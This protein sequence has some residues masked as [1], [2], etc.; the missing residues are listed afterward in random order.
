MSNK[1]NRNDLNKSKIVEITS[2][3]KLELNSTK[4]TCDKIILCLKNIWLGKAVHVFQFARFFMFWIICFSLIYA[5]VN[6]GKEVNHSFYINTN[7]YS[8]AFIDSIN[9]DL[10]KNKQLKLNIYQESSIKKA[11]VENA[12]KIIKTKSNNTDIENL[13]IIE[14]LFIFLLPF[15]V[16][17]GLY[18]YFETNFK[19]KLITETNIVSQKDIDLAEKALNT[20]KYLFISSMMAYVIIKI[21]ENLIL[22][23]EFNLSKSVIYLVFLVILMSYLLISHNSH[24]SEHKK[25]NE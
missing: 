18:Y 20:T 12:E 4:S 15:L 11:I 17:L 8:Q 23:N 1:F 5:V 7:E 14:H 3:I 16:S 22:E 9:K 24:S 10:D 19:S 2:D 6:F 21:I 13:K 25:I